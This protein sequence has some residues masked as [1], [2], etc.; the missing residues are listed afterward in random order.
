MQRPCS[1]KSESEADHL[2]FINCLR[3]V[4]GLDPITQGPRNEFQGDP[5]YWDE[6]TTK[7]AA[8]RKAG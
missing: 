4:L 5:T 2:Y 6:N 7:E 3:A 1:K 8:Q